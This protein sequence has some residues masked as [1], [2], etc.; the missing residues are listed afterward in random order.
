MNILFVHS[1]L[2]D[3]GLTPYAFRVYC[4]LARR[5]NKNNKAW[6]GMASMSKVCGFSDSTAK[7]SIKELE[8]R[9]MLTIERTNGGLQTNKYYL[10]EA[11]KW[12]PPG[13]VGTRSSQDPVPKEPTPGSHRPTKVI[14][15]GN[16][17]ED[18]SPGLES[19]PSKIPFIP[20]TIAETWNTICVSLPK[21]VEVTAK[22][23]KAINAR[24]DGEIEVLADVCRKIEASDFLTGR[25]SGTTPNWMSFDWIT[26]AT[27][28][29]KVI[30]GRYTNRDRVDRT[31]S[32]DDKF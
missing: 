3:M 10:T 23:F 31:T 7:R 21:V 4:H 28:Y 9:G 2:D 27:N 26:N 1:S 6:P 5:A 18:T 8:S 30:E 17:V 16:P 32:Q 29:A 25:T 11:S 20:K 15:Q 14:Q 13:S 19:D 24:C 12:T 22:R